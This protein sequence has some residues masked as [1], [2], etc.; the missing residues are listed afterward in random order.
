MM[1]DWHGQNTMDSLESETTSSR[2]VEQYWLQT[3]ID[4]RA[5]S[6]PPP[7]QAPEQQDQEGDR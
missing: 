4:D 1:A 7:A 5:E 3:V 6:A 2:S